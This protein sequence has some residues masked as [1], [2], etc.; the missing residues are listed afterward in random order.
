MTDSYS[1]D[2]QQTKLSWLWLALGLL[3][4]PCQTMASVSLQI[5]PNPVTAG[6]AVQLNLSVE[7]NPGQPDFNVLG[8]RLRIISQQS[9]SQITMTNG[10]TRRV[11]TWT[12]QLIPTGTGPIQIPPIPV[13]YEMTQPVVLQVLPQTANPSKP[14][15]LILEASIEPDPNQSPGYVQQELIY[16]QRLLFSVQL[17]GGSL[18]PPQADGLVVQE[19]GD[20]REYRTNRNGVSYSVMEW[21]YAIYP[22][23]SGTLTIPGPAFSGQVVRSRGNGLSGGFGNLFQQTRPITGVTPDISFTVKPSP[24]QA[25]QPWLPARNATLSA[26]WP[27]GTPVVR[28]GE[29]VVRQ[30]N[31]QIDGQIHTQ[32]PHSI[33][34]INPGPDFRVYPEPITRESKA[35][36]Q[37]VKTILTRRFTLVPN[38]P[39]QVRLPEI[40]VPWW[41]TATDQQREAR[42]EA[43]TLNVAP[44]LL[45]QTPSNPESLPEL[46]EGVPDP[47]PTVVETPA[48]SPEFIAAKPT[49]LRIWQLS[50]GLFGLL[51]LATLAL[52]FRQHRNARIDHEPAVQVDDA[53][54]HRKAL[55]LACAN[56][57]PQAAQAALQRYKQ[58]H[59]LQLETTEGQAFQAM[60]AKLN[61]RLY[62]D[63]T[64]THSDWQGAAFWQAFNAANKSSAKQQQST[65]KK[66][67]LPSLYDS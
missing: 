37:G 50:S 59:S 28:V 3:L 62:D 55:K 7:D 18:P 45:S 32:I 8:D 65:V 44:A 33:L 60:V 4:L 2:F 15:E 57:D 1:F 12:L 49:T 52:L 23:R 22:Q 47:T 46:P 54:K 29:P 26:V 39:G 61:Q 19:L 24:L 53:V 17:N 21:R 35:S 25:K 43:I 66:P 14:Q 30:L 20:R 13:G 48:A 40:T 6:A 41:D 9:G 31:L 63:R 58:Q 5:S 38:R 27:S 16:S 56:N 64:A 42:I 11:N 36:P 67:A 51:W 34:Q 10:E